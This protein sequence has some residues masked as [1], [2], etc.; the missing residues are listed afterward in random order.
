MMTYD[1]LV[2]AAVAAELKR[3][4][5]TGRIQQIRQ[6]NDS[7]ITFEIRSR[8]ESYL[9]FVS[10]HA[11]FSRVHLTAANQQVPQ[12]P[13][14]FCMLLRKH[15]KGAFITQIEQDGFDRVLRVHTEPP[16]GNRNTLIIELMGKH[17]NAILISDTGRILGAVKH[18]SAAVSRYRQVLPGRE[19]IAPPGGDKANPLTVSRA[20]F[21]TLWQDGIGA[22]AT[23][24][25]VKRWLVAAFS[26]IGPFMAE[27]ILLRAGSP[28]PKRPLFRFAARSPP[29]G[30]HRGAPALAGRGRTR[31]AP[32][33]CGARAPAQGELPLRAGPGPRE[34]GPPRPPKQ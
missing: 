6:H 14:N 7:D 12:T 34:P 22:E 24:E 5:V 29:G 2:L 15:I 20:G 32:E 25:G 8:G 27:E 23:S 16:D 1:G 33:R 28:A 19:Y 13:P 31:P 30:R 3:S 26:G 4:L 21:D 9:L 18:V 10:V 17:S 11:R